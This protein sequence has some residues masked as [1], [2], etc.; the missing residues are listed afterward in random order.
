MRMPTCHTRAR[1]LTCR[2]AKYKHTQDAPTGWPGLR[3]V[4]TEK[5][6]PSS[7]SKQ[8]QQ[9]QQQG[10]RASGSSSGGGAQAE[11]QPR[12]FWVDMPLPGP[13]A[14]LHSKVSNL[15]STSTT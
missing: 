3:A 2:H 15:S 6:S 8:Q 11:Q 7:S 12:Q 14:S 4:V 13:P 10:S 9:Q 1:V 5:L